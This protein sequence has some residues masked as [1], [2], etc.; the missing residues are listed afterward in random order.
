MLG[1]RQ[2]T[3]T[4]EKRMDAHPY[5]GLTGSTTD[6]HVF[7][8]LDA[9]PPNHPTHLLMLGFLLSNKSVR[10]IPLNHPWDKRTPKLDELGDLLRHDTRV[11]NMVHYARGNASDEEAFADLKLIMQECGLCLDGFQLNGP[12]PSPSLL[13]R[14]R[15]SFPRAPRFVLQINRKTLDDAGGTIEAVLE[16]L[17]VYEGLAHYVLFDMSG[18]LGRLLDVDQTLKFLSAYRQSGLTMRPVVA[19]GIG[20]KTLDLL[21]PI[22]AAFPGVSTD[23]EGACMGK[24]GALSTRRT[25]TAVG[26]LSTLFAKK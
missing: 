11:I 4:L 8:A 1:F 22:I 19:G 13:R 15:D 18:G 9:F 25:R 12:L 7:A 17:E 16:E 20:P 10:G 21:V 23:M 26:D 24:N 6:D 5:I 2:E 3:R 14:C